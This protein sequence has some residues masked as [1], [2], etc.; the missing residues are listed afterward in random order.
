[1]EVAKNRIQ[2][3]KKGSGESAATP[4]LASTLQEIYQTGGVPALYSGWYFSAGQS[5][6]EKFIHYYFY[7]IL[8][9]LYEKNVGPV[10]PFSNIAVGYI[11]EWM[12]LPFTMPIEVTSTVYQDSIGKSDRSW[13]A[14]AAQMK[15][16]G[17]LYEGIGAYVGLNWKPAIQ[18]AAFDQIKTAYIA[19]ANL[20]RLSDVQTFFLGVIAR[21][22][23]TVIVFPAQKAKVLAIAASKDGEKGEEAPPCGTLACILYT[24]KNGGLSALYAGLGP[25]LYRGMLSA[26]LMYFMKERIKRFIVALMFFLA[27][28]K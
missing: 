2:A 23:A 14:T 17:R 11:S 20:K 27:G 22:V 16:E 26:G 28:K 12:H 8:V 18:D 4:T 13:I 7:E 9:R 1:M 3:H 10:G 24:I 6:S 15:K 25:E 21:C 5:A 19:A